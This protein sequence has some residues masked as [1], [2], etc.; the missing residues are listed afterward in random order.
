VQTTSTPISR[1]ADIVFACA[2]VVL[3]VWLFTQLGNEAKFSGKG[4]LFAQPAFWPALSL[5]GMVIFGGLHLLQ[6]LRGRRHKDASKPEEAVTE[7]SRPSSLAWFGVFEFYLY[8]MVYVW[9]VP[10][11]GYLLATIIF[12]TL[13]ALR[14]G[15]RS[16]KMLGLAAASGIAIVILFKAFLSVKIPAASWYSTLPDR[17]ANFM[18]T[19]F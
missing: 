14:T 9:A 2:F 7:L 19:N 12:T 3:S 13:L 15:Y 10:V 1:T 8:F 11:L 6:I 17:L 16:K 18:I 4:K 5:A